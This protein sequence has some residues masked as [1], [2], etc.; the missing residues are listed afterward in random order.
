MEPKRISILV[1]TVGKDLN[2]FK[3]SQ[4]QVGPVIARAID[5]AEKIATPGTVHLY[6]IEAGNVNNYPLIYGSMAEAIG[7]L[8]N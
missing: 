8:M 5:T 2:E 3:Y 1:A 7:H 6:V 4:S